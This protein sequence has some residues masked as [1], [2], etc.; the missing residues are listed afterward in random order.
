MTSRPEEI[1]AS[2]SAAAEVIVAVEGELVERI[3]TGP[4]A[5]AVAQYVEQVIALDR[6]RDRVIRHHVQRLRDAQTPRERI[7]AAAA[8][9]R[10]R[11]TGGDEK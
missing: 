10:S 8:A 11:L 2:S 4:D 3:R 6:V 9:L 7:A 5:V 1:M